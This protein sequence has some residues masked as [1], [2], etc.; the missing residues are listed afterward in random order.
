MLLGSSTMFPRTGDGKG[1][2]VV[3]GIAVS[4]GTI[5]YFGVSWLLSHKIN[6][7]PLKGF[8]HGIVT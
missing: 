2:Q 4:S 7:S 1:G 3:T 5:A 6:R 8:V